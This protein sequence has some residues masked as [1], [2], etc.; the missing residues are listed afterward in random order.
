MKAS[1]TCFAMKHHY[2]GGVCYGDEKRPSESHVVL[3]RLRVYSNLPIPLRQN[4]SSNSLC[5]RM[6]SAN[7]CDRVST[8]KNK[9]EG[10]LNG[11]TGKGK[12]SNS[13]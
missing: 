10:I 7:T 8:I 6:Q 2:H 5:Y 9:T 13:H 3:K 12:S 1:F 11:N 4:K